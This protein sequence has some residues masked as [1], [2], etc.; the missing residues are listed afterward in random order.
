MQRSLTVARL[1]LYL[2]APLRSYK[3]VTIRKYQ[4]YIPH[5]FLRDDIKRF[6]VLEKDY[7]ADDPVEEIIP[8]ACVELILN[9]GSRYERADGV[10]RYLLPNVCLMGLQ[11]K[12][13]RL[14]AN[15]VVKIVAVRFFPW[16]PLSFFHDP[17]H[18]SGPTEVYLDDD[19]QSAIGKIAAHVERLD[20]DK[21]IADL[22]DFLLAKRLCSLFDL[23]R[24]Q[25]AAKLLYRTKGQFRISELAD[26]CNLSI[27]QLQ[28]QFEGATK[29]SPKVLAR[30]IRFEAI[31]N[32]LMFEPN[33]NLTELAYEFGFTDQAHFIN[34]FKAF[35]N[36]T[37]GEYAAEAAK[38]QKILHDHENVVFLQSPPSMLDYLHDKPE[39]E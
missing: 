22:E 28:R 26:Y 39:S 38:L 12:P 35:T 23:K 30:T 19:W 21:A 9:F 16:G 36:K 24:V 15:G 33:T 8:D 3:A 32:R 27:R 20:Y 5:S 6:W 34:D 1:I 18:T 37:P 14:Q 29:T 7:T 11:R 10:E 4:E 31:R 13:L 25:A 17:L 2:A